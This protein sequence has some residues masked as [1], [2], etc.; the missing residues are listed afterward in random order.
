M[1]VMFVKTFLVLID[2]IVI[3][4]IEYKVRKQAF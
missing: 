2:Y 1:E 3:D 4:H